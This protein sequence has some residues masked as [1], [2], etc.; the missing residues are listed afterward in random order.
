M[1]VWI[2]RRS[3]AKWIVLL[4]AALALLCATVEGCLP[5]FETPNELFFPL[6]ELEICEGFILLILILTLIMV[7]FAEILVIQRRLAR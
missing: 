4:M 7:H 6:L 3:M 1:F 2:V 5:I